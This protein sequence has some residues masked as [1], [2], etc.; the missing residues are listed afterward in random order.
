[1]GALLSMKPSL[2]GDRVP[3]GVAVHLEPFREHPSFKKLLIEHCDVIVPMNALK[4]AS[5]RWVR[6]RVNFTDAD[7]IISF[8]EQHYKRIHG[9]ALLWYHANP[10]W[11]DGIQSERELER[12][13]HEH[14]HS[15]VSR[16]AGRIATWD[17]VNE[18]VAHDPLS[19]GKWRDGIWY[20]LL[21]PRHVDLAFAAAAQADPKAKL[22]IN[23]YDLEDDSPRTKSRQDAIISIIQRLQDKNI[24]VHGVGLQAHL[25]AE[26]KIGVRN[27]QSF[28]KTLA[29]L[30]L[31]IA[32]TELD[33]IDWRLPSDPYE[34]DQL[35]AAKVSEFLSAVT[36][37]VS[38]EMITTWGMSD[39]HSW[40][41]ETF[42]RKDDARARP[43]PFDKDWQPKPMFDVLQQVTG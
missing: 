4:W 1:M 29:S 14:I 30:G 32:I 2:A 37:V 26:R 10:P 13:L 40:V 8:A 43:L 12:E 27:L 38:P 6:D 25:Y 11:L 18:V 39:V 28:L 33:V 42:P 19:Q 41:G 23:D 24:P 3:Y 9:H 35:A 15:V 5:L 22:F 31:K 20:R 7:E 17:V 34:R 36:S 21:G 16:Y